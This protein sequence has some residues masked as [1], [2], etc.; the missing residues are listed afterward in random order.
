M[1]FLAFFWLGLVWVNLGV[2]AQTEGNPSRPQLQSN[3]AEY[4]SAY[5]PS[6]LAQERRELNAILNMIRN[7]GAQAFI[8]KL[9]MAY[10]ER[11]ADMVGWLLDKQKLPAGAYAAYINQV[12]QE[13]AMTART[14]NQLGFA[15]QANLAQELSQSFR[16]QLQGMRA[17]PN[18]GASRYPGMALPAHNRAQSVMIQGN[19]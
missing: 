1:K 2:A 4:A 7:P 14:L 18:R 19:S 3:T 16:R 9:W 11:Q 17:G 12:S 13:L 15:A 6:G 10:I 8:Y 5:S